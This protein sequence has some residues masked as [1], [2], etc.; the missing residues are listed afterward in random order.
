MYAIVRTGGH[1]YRV[2]QGDIIEVERLAAGTGEAVVLDQ[3]LLVGGADT[4]IG[5]PLVE[6]ASV[7]ATVLDEI[8]GKKIVVFK[9]KRKN[10]YAVKTGHRQAY[11]RLRIDAIEA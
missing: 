11:T 2:A 3:V 1:Q 7:R 4:R 10:R 8:K 9:Y 5:S 6:G